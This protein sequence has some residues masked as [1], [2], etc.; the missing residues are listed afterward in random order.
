MTL[1][2]ILIG[3]A[4]IEAQ[5]AMWLFSLHPEE[6]AMSLTRIYD[7]NEIVL[8]WRGAES[9]HTYLEH[10]DQ[11]RLGVGYDTLNEQI[12]EPTSPKAQRLPQPD[13]VPM[14]RMEYR[15]S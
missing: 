10:I 12:E 4:V 2:L 7:L 11:V 8:R 13:R 3:E 14:A 1:T 15:H 9:G 5:K 6:V